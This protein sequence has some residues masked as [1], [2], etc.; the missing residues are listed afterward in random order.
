MTLLETAATE[1]ACEEH[2][3][4][5]GRLSD[6]VISKAFCL[7]AMARL[8]QKAPGFNINQYVKAICGSSKI[9]RISDQG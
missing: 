9:S 2:Q 4:V 5:N 7:S 8:E 1:I 6:E 3:R